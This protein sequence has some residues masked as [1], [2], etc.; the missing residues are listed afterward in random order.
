VDHITKRISSLAVTALLMAIAGCAGDAPTV[1]VA[2]AATLD[3]YLARYAPYEMSFDASPLPERERRMLRKLVEAAAYIDTAYRMQTSVSGLILR[4]SLAALPPDT[5]RTKLL[6]LLDRNGGPFEMLHGDSAFIGTERASPGQEMYPR[7]MTA[8]TFDAALAKLPDSGKEAFLSQ[9]TVIRRDGAGGYSAVPF[10]VGYERWVGPMARLLKEAAGLS[11]DEAFARFLRLKAEALL[12]DRYFDADT[13]WVGLSGNRYDII[14]GPDESYSDGIRGIKGK[15][16]ANIEVVDVEESKRL[17]LYTKHLNAMERN[18]PVGDEYKSVIEGV[19]SRF[20]VVNDIARTGEAAVG[21]QAVATNLPNDPEVHQ[22]KGTKKTFWKN[23]LKARYNTIIR[24]VGIRLIHPEQL[25][26]LTNDGFFQFVLMHEICH[27]LGPRVVKTGPDRGKSVNAVIGPAYGA[28]EEAKADLAGLHS[29]IY[30]MDRKVVDPAR[31]KE[32]CVSYL[33]S[34]LRT[35]RFGTSEAHGRAAAISLN[36]LTAN[37]GILYDPSVKRWSIDFKTF[38]AGVGRLT[39]ELIILEGNGDPEAVKE[40][41][42]KWATTTDALSTSLAAVGEI[43]VDILP[44]Y[45][46]R[47][48]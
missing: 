22:Q 21:Y 27:A 29:L 10:H 47:W 25:Q 18:L 35:I 34:L 44:N 14:F 48:E 1:P 38:R 32:Y 46:V 36:Y 43:P 8:E 33:G 31:E 7:G 4:D 2:P 45:S 41:F 19:T 37:G 40:F 17:D 28:L 5:L 16:Q 26:F 12:T 9:Y 42:S 13:A 20:V 3:R 11:D 39:R 6:K 15:Y 24:P 30:L 23:M